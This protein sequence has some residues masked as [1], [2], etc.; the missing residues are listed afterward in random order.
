MQEKTFY[1]YQSSYS[2][3]KIQKLS[4]EMKTEVLTDLKPS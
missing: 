2:E 4:E 1:L 3:Q